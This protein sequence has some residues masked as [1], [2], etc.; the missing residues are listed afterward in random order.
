M[1]YL[2]HIYLADL[3]NTSRIGN[4]LGDFVRGNVDTLPFSQNYKFGI[5]LHRKIDVFTDSHPIVIQSKNRMSKE[6][7]RFAGIIIDIA[8]DHFL[9][10]N[11]KKFS[12]V[13]LSDFVQSFYNELM[14]QN[15]KLPEKLT[16]V[17]P[18][19][20]KYNWLENYKMLDGISKSLNGLAK[21]FKRENSLLNS[22][23]EIE[24]NYKE[25]ESDFN[26]FFKD[27]QQFTLKEV[28]RT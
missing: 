17:L 26:I 19:I 22:V 6:R 4:F 21:R 13:K 7:R 11:W 2:A 9:A 3:T 12:S 8:Y 10:K 15:E 25:L 24:Q 1:N 20:I 23:I 16:Y 28:R 5:I 14:N 27:L 18:Y